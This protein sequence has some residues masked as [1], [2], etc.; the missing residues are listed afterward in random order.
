MLLGLGLDFLSMGDF[1]LAF[2][3]LGLNRVAASNEKR[4]TC[5]VGF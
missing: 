4:V 3:K 5:L 2:K 1:G